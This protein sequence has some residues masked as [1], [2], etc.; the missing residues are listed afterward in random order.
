MQQGIRALATCVAAAL[1]ATVTAPVFAPLVHDAQAAAISAPAAEAKASKTGKKKPAVKTYQ[2]TGVILA[3]DKSTLT[4][5]KGKT[6][7]TK[8]VFSKLEKMRMTGDVE[9]GAR[10]TVYYRKQGDEVIAHRVVVKPDKASKE[11]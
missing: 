4:V 2:F 10:V 5:Q 7:P 6:K 9:K 8:K 1:I 11:G 3:M